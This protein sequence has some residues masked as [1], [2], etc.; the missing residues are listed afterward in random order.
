MEFKREV[1][2]LRVLADYPDPSIVLHHT[3]WTQDDHHYILYP[4]AA[5]NLRDF[6]QRY[7]RAPLSRSGV[8]WFLNQ[9]EGLASAIKHVHNLKQPTNTNRHPKA[10][11]TGC[12]Y[13]IKAENILVFEQIPKHHPIFK[14]SDFGVGVFNKAKDPGQDSELTQE[15]KGTRR[16]FAPE[17]DSK[18][19]SRPFDMWALGCVFLELMVW[20]FGFFESSYGFSTAR[21]DCSTANPESRHDTFYTKIAD[22]TFDLK[23]VVRDALE[24][25]ESK[26]CKKLRAFRDVIEVI[27]G[28]LRIDPKRRWSARHVK[29]KLGATIRQALTDL[30]QNPNFYHDQYAANLGGKPFEQELASERVKADQSTAGSTRSPSP[31]S[32]ERQRSF[33]GGQRLRSETRS[34]QALVHTGSVTDLASNGR[35]LNDRLSP[36]DQRE[37]EALEREMQQA[38]ADNSAGR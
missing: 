7:A 27:R 34:S 22:G 21:F 8:L 2:M 14:I 32:P 3:S 4:K 26:H 5:F 35:D 30:Q 24:E 9:L 36:S 19:V 31:S 38:A 15:A 18:K 11:L 6:M 20:Q 17:W 29:E 25:L 16:Y 37:S 28:L 10:A 13:D 12:H 23:S 33:D 1:S